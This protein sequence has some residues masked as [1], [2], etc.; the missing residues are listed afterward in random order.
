MEPRDEQKA[1]HL[2]GPSESSGNICSVSRP[3]GGESLI[4]ERL[5]SITEITFECGHGLSGLLEAEGH[6]FI[7]P[8]SCGRSWAC[9]LSVALRDDDADLLHDMERLTGLGRLGSTPARAS[10]RPQVYWAIRSKLECLALAELLERYPM[11]GRKRLEAKVWSSAV[12]RW[13][14]KQY[15]C[16]ASL[17][18]ELTSMAADLRSLRRYLEPADQGAPPEEDAGFLPYFGGFFTGDGSFALANRRARVIVKLRRDDR[19][20]LEKFQS[21]FGMGTVHDL[22]P[23]GQASPAAAWIVHKR[24]DVLRA[25]E[26]LDAAGLRGRKQR[27]YLAWREGAREVAAASLAGRPPDP[28]VVRAAKDA[29]AAATAY[30]PRLATPHPKDDAWQLARASY[31]SVLRQWAGTCDGKLS[32]TRYARERREH[33]PYWPTRNTITAAFGSW[34]QALEAAGLFRSA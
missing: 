21:T 24:A 16:D 25:I 30:K 6:L 1:T 10:S 20:L 23:E 15:G 9:G 28:E 14:A 11:R 18:A 17:A 31:V 5:A 32:C 29:L 33:H 8:R 19:P 2:L 12:R 34:H 13:A 4:R 26:L 7:K 3:P 27:Q 22:R